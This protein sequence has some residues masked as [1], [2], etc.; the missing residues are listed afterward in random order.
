MIKRLENQ[1]T[2]YL[3]WHAYGILRYHLDREFNCNYN[4]FIDDDDEV[5]CASRTLIF[6]Y[7]ED[8]KNVFRMKFPVPL[9][10]DDQMAIYTQIKMKVMFS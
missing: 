3:M 10:I 4:L 5:E 2:T 8:N 1:Y 7:W 9:L 6:S